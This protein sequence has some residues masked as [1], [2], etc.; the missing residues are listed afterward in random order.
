M[1][2]ESKG[3]RHMDGHRDKQMRYEYEGSRNAHLE[4]SHK[5]REENR[6]GWKKQK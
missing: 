6:E 2:L 4:T 1:V 5:K 3:H